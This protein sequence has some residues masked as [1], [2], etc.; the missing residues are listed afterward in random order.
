LSV[1]S[2]AGVWDVVVVDPDGQERSLAGG[3]TVT[4]VTARV[5]TLPGGPGLPADTNSDGTYD[6]VISTRRKVFADVV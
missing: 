6:K 3:F 5:M 4:N 2:A 1:G